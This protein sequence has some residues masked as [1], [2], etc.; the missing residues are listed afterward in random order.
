M[1]NIIDVAKAAGLSTATVSRTLRSPEKVAEETRARVMHAIEKVGYRPNLLARNLR[2]D[3]SFSILV[4]VPGIANPF[5]ARATAGI[6][7]TAWRRG[8]AVFL[9]DTRDSRERE[10]H[11]EQLVET[12]LADGVIQLSPDYDEER[13][14]TAAYPVV[15]ACGCEFTAAPSVRIDNVGAA[16]EMVEYLIAGGHRRIAA[17]SGPAANP[18]AIERMRGYREALEGAGIAFDPDLVRFGDFSMAS[19]FEAAAS[20]VGLKTRP[21][22]IF[23][24]NDEMAIGAIHAATGAGL[25]VPGDMS[26]VGFDDIAFAAHSSPALTTISQP[27]EEMGAIACE[28]L[29]DWIE[30]K[31]VEDAAHV[32]PHKLIERQS[33]AAAPALSSRSSTAR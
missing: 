12:R 13:R 26:I 29:I 19:G 10:E 9:G 15:H 17:I 3:R 11:Y 1:S 33:S 32:L 31:P 6:E 14:K 5:F 30:G 7:A 16:R 4:L 8:Y 21:T 20:L 27:A 28:I 2:S 18:H 23:S 24:M 22:A 25:K